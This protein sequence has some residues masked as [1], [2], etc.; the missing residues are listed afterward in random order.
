M[1]VQLL[2]LVIIHCQA[3]QIGPKEN[4][5][6]CRM[7]LKIHI[8][9]GFTVVLL[10][11]WAGRRSYNLLTKACFHEGNFQRWSLGN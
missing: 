1:S 4:I 2:R 10:T 8:N 5:K 6:S 11:F 9:N 3:D 7:S